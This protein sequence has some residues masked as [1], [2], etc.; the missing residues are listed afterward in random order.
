MAFL[1]PDVL[2]AALAEIT[3]NGTALHVT[4][5]AAGEPATY[6]NVTTNTL[7]NKANPTYTGPAAGDV[8]GRKITVDAVTD[9]SGTADGTAGYW[10][11]VD[12]VGT[13]LL[14]AGPLS[15][16]KSVATDATLQLT[17]FDIEMPAPA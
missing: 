8:S 17:A 6:A 5:N 13:R 12:T 4:S 2:D 9:G 7:G 14:A 10:A 3:A 11:I 1:N 16:T 15:A